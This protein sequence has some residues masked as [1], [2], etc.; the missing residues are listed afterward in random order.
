[1]VSD[2]HIILVL[3][4]KKPKLGFFLK[5]NYA[6]HKD[7]GHNT[8]K[9]NALRDEI[10]RLIRARHFREFLENEPQVATFH[11]RPRQHRSEGIRE[12]LTIF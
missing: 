11:E 8:E 4:T 12:V 6:Y 5:K 1:M 10:E 3:F 2:F 9:C 7:I